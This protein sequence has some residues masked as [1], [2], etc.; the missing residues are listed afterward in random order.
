LLVV[1]WTKLAV[2]TPVASFF[3]DTDQEREQMDQEQTDGEDFVATPFQS[4]SS[5]HPPNDLVDV[6]DEYRYE[7]QHSV[8]IDLPTDAIY[9]F[10]NRAS[11]PICLGGSRS[12][13]LLY[14][15]PSIP[16]PALVR[17]TIQL[18]LL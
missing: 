16:S 12:A 18:L 3:S 2:H 17:L 1:F 5:A 15:E 14:V 9:S 10:Q 7:G 11:R 6:F 13:T 8:I 4:R